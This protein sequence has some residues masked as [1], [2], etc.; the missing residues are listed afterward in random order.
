M[1]RKSSKDATVEAAAAAAAAAVAAATNADMESIDIEAAEVTEDV[2][3]GLRRLDQG[4]N[5][6]TW[7]VYCDAPVEREGFVEKLKT[8]QL[9]EQRFKSKYGAGEYRVIGRTQDGHYVRG[10]HKVIKISAILSDGAGPAHATDPIALL[11]EMSL[12]R[13]ETFKQY[14]TILAAPLATLGA[15]L[16]ARRP[17]L[18]I[19]ALI[20]SLRPQQSSLTEM[21]TALANLK[22]L[23]GGGS[24]TLD[25]VL[26]VVERLQ[27]LPS[28]GGASD[29][30]WLGVVRD[31]IRETAPAAREMLGQLAAQR[32]QPGIA[33]LVVHPPAPAAQA[34]PQ[35]APTAQAPTNGAASTTTEGKEA[36]MWKLVEP[37][38]RRKAEDLHESAA[39]NMSVELC[40]EHLLEAAEKKFGGL[41][42]ADELRALLQRP[43]WW[44]HVVLFYPPLTPFQAWVNDVRAEILAMLEDTE[45][46]RAGTRETNTDGETT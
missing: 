41:L 32:P 34:L 43:D 5:R 28:G 19:P 7:Y 37:W 21:T 22:Q 4:G 39:S 31:V 2:L 35:P 3:E 38:L 25:M 27:D 26:K 18:D 36:D 29:T 17:S 15:A 20:S 23:E 30:G 10:S 6:V 33:P 12:Q 42:T 46:K 14:A 13:Q 44:Q 9:D 8:E 11:R 16:I 40:A 45:G 24:G 1:G